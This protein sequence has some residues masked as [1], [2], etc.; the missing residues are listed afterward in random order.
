MKKIIVLAILAIGLLA[1]GTR[2]EAAPCA[3]G[4]LTL[5]FRPI[6]DTLW[7][8]QICTEYGGDE[9][10]DPWFPTIPLVLG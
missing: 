6:G 1:G 3:D 7:F 8:G 2:A 10:F 9:T 5:G 4:T